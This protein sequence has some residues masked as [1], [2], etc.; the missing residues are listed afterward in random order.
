MEAISKGINMKTP[1]EIAIYYFEVKKPRR[2]LLIANSVILFLCIALFVV[3]THAFAAS[4]PAGSMNSAAVPAVNQFA[5]EANTAVASAVSLPIGA[6]KQAPIPNYSLNQILKM[7]LRKPSHVTADDLNAVASA[8]LTG[9]GGAFAQAEKTYHVN[10]VFLMAIASVESGKG[11]IMFRPNNMFGYGQSG[12]SSK[13][14][15]IQVVASGLSSRYLSPGGGLYG[16]SP[17]ISGV[18]KRY[19]TSSTWTGKVAQYMAQYYAG[20]CA[21]REAT[22]KS[23][24]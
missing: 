23:G 18:S 5:M 7:D 15:G 13:A 22:L 3:S 21:H 4:S 16:G 20:I 17:T 2:K 1:A 8:G 24:S 14:Q 11:T 19:C 12:F 9:L 6:A 10:A